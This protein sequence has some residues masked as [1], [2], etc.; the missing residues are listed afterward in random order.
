MTIPGHLIQ[1]NDNTTIT[2]PREDFL[3]SNNVSIKST[4]FIFKGYKNE[5]ERIVNITYIHIYIHN[6]QII[7]RII[8][9]FTVIKI[10]L[11][12]N[13]NININEIEQNNKVLIYLYHL[14]IQIQLMLNHL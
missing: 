10:H 14:H 8:F 7:S 9:S 3:S 11:H 6:R 12:Q 13:Q 5:K 4:P 2:N 1:I